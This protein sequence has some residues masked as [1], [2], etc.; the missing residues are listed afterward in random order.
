MAKLFDALRRIVNPS[1]RADGHTKASPRR[2]PQFV[3]RSSAKEIEQ[4][5]PERIGEL[6]G[7]A[8]E[9]VDT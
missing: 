3:G 2:D 6:V 9:R 5:P 7:H 4:A 1:F 8:P